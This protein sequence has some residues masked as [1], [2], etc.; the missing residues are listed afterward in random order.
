MNL[1]ERKRHKHKYVMEESTTIEGVATIPQFDDC[2]PEIF[3]E[4][5]LEDTQSTG[6]GTSYN[7]TITVDCYGGWTI[8]Y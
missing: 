6:L 7:S 8:A 2:A 3:D 1:Q 5:W 4:T